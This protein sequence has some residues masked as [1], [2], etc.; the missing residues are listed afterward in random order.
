MFSRGGC[1]VP[2]EP[3]AHL[4]SIS[5]IRRAGAAEVSVLRLRG[6]VR[7]A[8]A[9]ELEQRL[10]EAG[11]RS[12][13]LVVDLSELDYVTSTGLGHLLA[14]AG[15]QERRRGW[16]RIVSPSAAVAMIFELSGVGETLRIYESEDRAL[17]DLVPRA[18]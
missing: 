14:Q 13:Y 9:L 16:L 6:A 7:T 17:A 11:E 18:A 15:F 1:I 12:P 2:A 5:R 10:A 8:T 3:E 4:I